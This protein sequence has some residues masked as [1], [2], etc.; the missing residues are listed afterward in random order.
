MPGIYL[1]MPAFQVRPARSGFPSGFWRRWAK[2][3]GV[4]TLA[5]LSG[6]ASFSTASGP[7]RAVENPDGYA[8]EALDRTLPDSPVRILFDFRYREADMRFRG[9]GVAR[10]EPP[11]KVRVDLF[12]PQGETLFQAALVGS[13]LRIPTWAPREMA[14]PPPLLWASLGV[15][16]PDPTWALSGGDHGRDGRV[17]LRYDSGPEEEL[18]FAVENG[19]LVRAELHRDGHLTEEVGLSLAE[20]SGTVQETVYR[21][22]AEFLELTFSLE[23]VE[24]VESFPSDIWDP[25]R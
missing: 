3:A 20:T 2:S 17:V 13:D 10:V 22:L 19:R 6:C 18:R 14:P 5:A 7:S 25:G 24:T 16:R 9:R 12:S 21:N 11:Y 1:W 23:T 4:G 15:F 8:Q